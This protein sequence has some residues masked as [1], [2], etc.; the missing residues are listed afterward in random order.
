MQGLW[1]T[2]VQLWGCHCRTCLR[3]PSAIGR[4]ATTT[5]APRRRKALASHVF[6]ASYS[7]IM[8]TAAVLDASHKDRKRAELDLKITEAKGKLAKLMQDSMAG[9]LAQLLEAS[10]R[11]FNTFYYHWPNQPD[12]LDVF[13][14]YD[15]KYLLRHKRRVAPARRKN[16]RFCNEFF[17]A[18]RDDWDVSSRSLVLCRNAIVAEAAD[19]GISEREPLSQTQLSKATEQVIELVD[20]LLR[21]AYE[22]TEAEAPDSHPPLNSPD[23]AYHLIR[24]LKSDGHP[25]YQYPSIDS[26]LTNTV[27]DR[28]DELN[29]KAIGDWVP[30]R[31][32]HYVAKICYN[33]LVSDVPPGIRNYN[34]LVFGFTKLGEHKLG[35]AVV[36]H[37][38]HRTHLKPTR[39]TILCLLQHYRLKNDIVG[40]HKITQRILGYDERGIKLRRRTV[41][42]IRNI[43]V[44]RK[45]ARDS[46]AVI[47]RDYAVELPK[48]YW[49]HYQVIL[50]GLLDFAMLKH[51]IE[52]FFV[53][54][55][56]GFVPRGGLVNKLLHACLSTLDPGSIRVL[57]DG[58]IRNIGQTVSMLSDGRL[59]RFTPAISRKLRRL[60]SIRRAQMFEHDSTGG[61]TVLPLAMPLSLL[62]SIIYPTSPLMGLSQLERDPV[63]HFV[64]SIWINCIMGEINFWAETLDGIEDILLDTELLVHRVDLAVDLVD[65]ALRR[66]PSYADEIERYKSMG[67]IYWMASECKSSTRRLKWLDNKVREITTGKPLGDAFDVLA[68]RLAEPSLGQTPVPADAS[69]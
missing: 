27:R 4:R 39:A 47:I 28:L 37:V 5:A 51:A 45:W 26:E 60:L 7:A 23:S 67:K 53:C 44:L 8:A 65:T 32:E 33:L 40:F 63:S 41:D 1:S 20:R 48:F 2:A 69:F 61:L 22:V 24:L 46:Q 49:S 14:N 10:P 30:H 66:T 9:D 54:L 15:A 56:Q 34:T 16:K 42:E 31:R 36:N 55:R 35:Q 64:T 50:E 17:P 68:E 6:I 57:I 58:L 43:P 19:T 52:V 3:P 12:A 29:L 11:Y 38:L 21:V 13:C 25:S 18:W 62:G 59:G